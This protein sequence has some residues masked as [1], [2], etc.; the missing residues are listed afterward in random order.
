MNNA[1]VVHHLGGPQVLEYQSVPS[2]DPAPGEVRVKHTAIGLNFIDVYFRTGLYP[3]PALPFTPG[4]EAAGVVDAVGAA[5]DH[6]SVGERVAYASPP[7]GA[8]AQIRTIAAD[9]IVRIPDSVSDEDAAAM[10]LQ[11]M[12]AQ[13]LLRQTYPIAEGDVVLFH[14]AAGGVGLIACRW[15]KYLGATVIGTVGTRQKAELARANGCDYTIVY[16]EEDVVQRVKDI[17]RGEGVSVVYDSVGKD[18][19][20]TSLDCLSRRGM[21]VSFGNSSGPVAAFEPSVLSAKGSLFMTRPTLMD[22]TVTR[23]ELTACA[24]ELF[25]MMAK[26]VVKAHINQKFALADAASAHRAL[27]GRETTGS[28][29]LLP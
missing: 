11:G 27:E 8:Y 26:K 2:P 22:Y 14:A 25:A 16:T 29:V 9:R 20:A 21:L 28:T 18:T 6:V 7:L 13:Y 5:V 19:F 4:L 17:T 1:I 23:A 12:T 24:E 15:A 10:M 3:A